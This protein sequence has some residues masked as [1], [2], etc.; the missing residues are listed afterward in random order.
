MTAYQEMKAAKAV[1]TPAK[2]GRPS[3]YPELVRELTSKGKVR[4]Q[5]ARRATEVLRFRYKDEYNA[6]QREENA[7]LTGTLMAI[8]E[9]GNFETSEELF[10]AFKAEIYRR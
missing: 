3:K 5:A 8:Y 6:L 4:N 2:R 7:A 10:E 9:A 1:K